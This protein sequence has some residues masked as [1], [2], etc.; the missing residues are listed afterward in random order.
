MPSPVF[1]GETKFAE[2][3]RVCEMGSREHNLGSHEPFGVVS[4][5]GHDMTGA[6]PKGAKLIREELLVSRVDKFFLKHLTPIEDRR[7]LLSMYDKPN[8]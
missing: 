5:Y 7:F 6:I 8:P 1:I 2:W 4:E 3:C